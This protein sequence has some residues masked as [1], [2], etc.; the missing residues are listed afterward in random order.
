MK[1]KF[2]SEASLVGKVKGKDQFSFDCPECGETHCFKI[3]VE[4]EG[5]IEICP[6]CKN[7]MMLRHPAIA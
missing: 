4:E 2:V 6:D 3:T 1:H 5:R 7:Q